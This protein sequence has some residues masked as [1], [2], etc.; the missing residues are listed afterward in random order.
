MVAELEPGECVAMEVVVGDD[1]FRSTSSR[2]S[3]V[4]MNPAPPVMKIRFPS[5]IGGSLDARRDRPGAEGTLELMRSALAP[6]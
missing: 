5:S 6:K 1:L 4:P 2:A 3:V